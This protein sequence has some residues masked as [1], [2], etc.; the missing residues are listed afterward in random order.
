MPLLIAENYVNQAPG[1][2]APGDVKLVRAPFGFLGTH[3]G[4]KSKPNPPISA[5]VW[6]YLCVFTRVLGLRRLQAPHELSHTAVL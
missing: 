2:C 6:R 3:W 5:L 1:I 4:T